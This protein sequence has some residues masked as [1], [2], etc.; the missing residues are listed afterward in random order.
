MVLPPIT[1]P[2]SM[3]TTL[4]PVWAALRAAERPAPPAPMTR[5]SVSQVS[6]ALGFVLASLAFIAATSR[7]AFLAASAT[8]PLMPLEAKVAPVTESTL[9]LWVS[10]MR[11]GTRSR[12]TFTTLG[13]SLDSRILIAWMRPPST[14][15]WTFIGPCIP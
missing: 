13:V 10:T 12:A 3:R 14:E 4:A 2:F 6:G 11:R 1:E 5:T 15:I 9:R 8:A 7:P